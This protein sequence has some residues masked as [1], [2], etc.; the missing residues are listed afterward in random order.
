VLDWASRHLV[1]AVS[2]LLNLVDC[3][4]LLPPKLIARKCNDAK[5][6]SVVPLLEVLQFTVVD[7]RKPTIGCYVYDQE[8]LKVGFRV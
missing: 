2:K 8:H 6:L 1:L 3:P 4:R 7:V 5:R